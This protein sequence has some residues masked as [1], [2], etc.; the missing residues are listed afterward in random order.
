MS[1][2]KLSKILDND[3]CVVSVFSR[4]YNQSAHEDLYYEKDPESDELT[5]VLAYSAE[6]KWSL[7][8]DAED[9]I[10]LLKSKVRDEIFEG[11]ELSEED[12]RSIDLKIEEIF[13]QIIWC[14][15]G[16]FSSIE[17]SKDNKIYQLEVD[18]SDM[19]KIFLG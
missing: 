17:I 15:R 8:S 11:V 18:K 9:C 5:Q 12:E 2:L 14:V 4:R 3:D 6:H 19:Q 1:K 13:N 10:S 16:Y 7:E